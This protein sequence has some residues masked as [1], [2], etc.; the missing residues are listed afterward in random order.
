MPPFDFNPNFP[1]LRSLCHRI[2]STIEKARRLGQ[3][4]GHEIL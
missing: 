3:D 4:R 1:V 2:A